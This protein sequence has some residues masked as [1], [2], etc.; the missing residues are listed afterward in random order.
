MS[1]PAAATSGPVVFDEPAPIE[2]VNSVSTREWIASMP[3]DV[4]VALAA[5]EMTGMAVNEF[6]PGS[7]FYEVEV[8][9]LACTPSIGSVLSEVIDAT[10]TAA[11]R[12]DVEGADLSPVIS[13]IRADTI[14][15]PYLES[16]A[17][18]MKWVETNK[19]RFDDED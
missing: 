18:L 8:D 12:Y 7:I 2:S 10:R 3:L 5:I 17:R 1:R 4:R 9:F 15:H 16:M 19:S 6:E 14:R 13:Y 11:D